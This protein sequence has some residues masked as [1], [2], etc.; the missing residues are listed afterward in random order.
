MN[1]NNS[2]LNI[3]STSGLPAGDYVYLNT[4]KPL[5]ADTIVP[6][7]T[8]IFT[9]ASILQPS[10]L[11]APTVN[12]FQFFINGQNIAS[13]FVS[14]NNYV[15]GVSITFDTAQTKITLEVDDQVTAVGKF[16]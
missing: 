13:S 2:Y 12:D 3:T 8:A 5:I 7:N 10:L 1:Y 9:G 11:P 15:G 16:V 4:N 14:F 6:P